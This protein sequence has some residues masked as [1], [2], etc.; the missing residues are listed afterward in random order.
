MSNKLRKEKQTAK[1]IIAL[2]IVFI[3]VF[4]CVFFAARGKFNPTATNGVAM[5]IMS[6][7]QRAFSWVGSQL[8]FVRDT[9]N[10]M[11]H[12]HEQ[13]KLLREEVEILRAQNLT[14]SEYASE[15][16]RLRNL[17]GYKQ[18]AIQ[19]DLVAASV[20]GRESASWSS[21]IL[22]N[23]GTL[24]G[25]ANN[26][27]VVTELGLVG[28]VMEAGVNSSKVQLIID[29]RSSV[30]T[31]IQRPESRVAGIVEGDVKNPNHP[32]MV[33]IPKDSDVKVDDMVVTSGFGGVYPKGLVVGKIIEI[34]NEE[35]GLL[36]YGVI[37]TS[38][39]F[40]KLEDVAVIVASREAPPEPLQPPPQTPG[41]ETDPSVT[42]EKLQHAQQQIQDAQQQVQD[43]QQQQLQ[44]AGYVSE[45]A[46]DNQ[47]GNVAEEATR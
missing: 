3:S 26:M 7:F 40:Q 46:A 2:I 15:N 36:E 44:Q 27:A 41:T 35:G 14:A 32:R 25:V 28:H 34:R 12:L 33:N 18:A 45:E 21:V 39:D 16:Q 23:R 43:A 38:V 9:V 30:G 31:L 20:I 42:A 47:T 24:D 19:F 4:C 1:K 17:L 37:D 13:N 10:E 11:S 29:P 22:I 8:S 5:M 6:P